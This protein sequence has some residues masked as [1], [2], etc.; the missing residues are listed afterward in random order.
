M[1]HENYSG[2]NILKMTRLGE[3]NT[4]LNTFTFW[5]SLSLRDTNVSLVT[6]FF[7]NYVWFGTLIDFIICRIDPRW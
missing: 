4:R 5:K 1:I 2:L 6:G 3:F 7:L